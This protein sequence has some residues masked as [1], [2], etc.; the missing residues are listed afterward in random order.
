ML[1]EKV[2]RTIKKYGMLSAGDRVVVA[3]SGGPDSVCLVSMLCTLAPEYG[4]QLH[5]AHLDHMFRGPGSAADA[6]FVEHLA[7]TLGIPATIEATDVPAFCRERGLSA[8]EGARDVRYRFLSRVADSVGAARTALGHTANDQ[9]ETVVMRLVRGAGMEA[10]AGISPVREKIIRPLLEAT[11]TEILSYLKEA[12]LD[13]VT[14]PTN[15]QPVYTR[16]RIRLNVIPE[17]EQINPNAVNTLAAGAALLRDES[18]ALEELLAPVMAVLLRRQGGSVRLDRRSFLALLPAVRRRALRTA[19]AS[20]GGT[21]SEFSLLQT[22]EAVRFLEET[23]TGRALDLPG[24]LLLER[25]YDDFV[26]RPRQA[27]RT[28]R[29]PLPVPGTVMVP[30]LSLGVD[31]EVSEGPPVPRAGE[32]Y[33]WQAEFDYAKIALPLCLRSRRE[34]DRFCPAGMGGRSKKLQDYFVDERLSRS[35]RDEVPLLTTEADILWVVGLRTDERFLPGPGTKKVL[36][37][38]IKEEP[39]KGKE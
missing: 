39:V 11:R 24:G 18:A 3:V 37:V 28:F 16:N 17:L 14:D 10:L 19:V 9:A 36:R 8:Q 30:E 20:L 2:K 4:L 22:D 13:F 29:V 6:R 35:R 25:S 15:E 31:T 32:N 7:A 5:I 27:S 23:Q 26:V 34:G 38:T 1:I 33:L 12:A 21:V